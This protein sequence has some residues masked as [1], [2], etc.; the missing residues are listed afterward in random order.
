[1]RT[2][3]SAGITVILSAMIIMAASFFM[4]LKASSKSIKVY[5]IT[6]EKNYSKDWETEKIYLSNSTKRSYKNGLQTKYETKGYDRDGKVTHN[7]KYTN[8]Y[9]K[10]ERLK[11][12][13]DYTDGKLTEVNKYTYKEKKGTVKG[14]VIIYNGQNKKIGKGET[15]SKK[16][17]YTSKYYDAKGK[18]TYD[19]SATFDKKGRQIK[20]SSKNYENGK[21]TWTDVTNYK[22]GNPTKSVSISYSDGKEQGRTTT[23]YSYS[24]KTVNKKSVYKS[25]DYSYTTESKYTTD[26]AGTPIYSWEKEYDSEGKL[27]NSY[28]FKYEKYTSGKVKGCVKKEITLLDGKEEGRK[29]LTVKQIKRKQ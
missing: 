29:E 3:T 22:N 11:T 18:L 26:K 17:K 8:S 24:G 2:R 10:K 23:T 25:S 7:Y 28:T 21:L 16:T 1:M 15:V 9:D 20:G 5:V 14:T 13:K 19:Y 4:P 6:A 12:S 27:R